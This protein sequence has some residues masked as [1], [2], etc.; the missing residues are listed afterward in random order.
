MFIHTSKRTIGNLPPTLLLSHH[1]HQH[2]SWIYFP[3]YIHEYHVK[4]YILVSVN[5]STEG[6]LSFG[7]LSHHHQHYAGLLFAITSG[8]YQ[9][10]WNGGKEHQIHWHFY[11]FFLISIEYKDLTSS[12]DVRIEC[13]SLINFS[14]V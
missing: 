6:F 8:V 14:S 10:E 11:G 13:C 4:S 5:V 7:L 1:H 2:W 9:M 3:P 12:F